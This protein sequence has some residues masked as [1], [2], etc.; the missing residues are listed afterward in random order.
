MKAKLLNVTEPKF[1][2]FEIVIEIQSLEEAQQICS[3]ANLS[4][5]KMA[6]ITISNGCFKDHRCN[7]FHRAGLIKLVEDKLKSMGF[8][9]WGK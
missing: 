6:E 1:E 4:S 9:I 7:H 8:N 5:D 3:I 2:P